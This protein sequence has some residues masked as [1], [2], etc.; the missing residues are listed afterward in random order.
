MSLSN[1]VQQIDSISPF[2]TGNVASVLYFTRQSDRLIEH[3]NRILE[4][5]RD[6]YQGHT[7]L[8]RAYL[9]KGLYDQAIPELQRVV[10]P[11]S[12]DGMA[13]LGYAYAMAGRKAESLKAAADLQSL[14]GKKY[15]SPARLPSI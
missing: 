3:A 10:D 12:G 8:G 14:A 9:Q 2:V 4:L 13:Q 6:S 5:D 7:W 15:S 11:Q 1:R